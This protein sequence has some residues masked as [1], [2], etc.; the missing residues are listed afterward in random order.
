MVH[1]IQKSSSNLGGKA[2]FLSQGRSKRN[3]Q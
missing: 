3:R 2:M 1:R